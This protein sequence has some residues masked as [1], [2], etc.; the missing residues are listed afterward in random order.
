MKI[1]VNWLRNYVNIPE[2]T[3][4]Y[5]LA[6]LLTIRTTEVEEIYNLSATF[7]H[8]VIGKIEDIKSHP[9]ADKLQIT[10][11][12]IGDKTLQIIC[13]AKNISIGQKVAVALPGAMIRW[14]GEGNLV[15]LES[16]KIRNI[17]SF[18]MICAGEEIGIKDKTD[19]ILDLSHLKAMPGTPLANALQKDDWIIDID[20]KSLT[21]RPDC[22]G[23]YGIARE[24][25]AITDQK[26]QPLNVFNKYDSTKKIIIP[27]EVKN[28]KLCPRYLSITIN[29]IKV[30]PSP[31]WLQNALENT[32]NRT[33]NN[34]VDATNF[35]MLELGNP[36]HAFD[37]S[38]I[39]QKL[40]IRNANKGEKIITLDNEEKTLTD[41]M[42]VVAD[43]KRILAIAGVKGGINSGITNQTTSITLEAA[44]FDPI[45]IRQTSGKIG[46]RT[47]AVQRFEKNLDPILAET[48]LD[49]L[50]KII[51]DICPQAEIVSKKNDINNFKYKPHQIKLNLKKVASKI[52]INIPLNDIIE[53]L[54]KLEFKIISTYPKTGKIKTHITVE[55]PSFRATKDIICPE[56]LI[57]EITRLYGYEKLPSKIPNLSIRLPEVNKERKEEN[58]IRQIFSLE[59]GFQ[60]CIDYSF[61][62]EKTLQ[63]AGL[64]TKDHFKLKNYLSEEQTHLRI[65][66]LPNLLLRAQ[67]NLKNFDSFKLYEIGRTYKPI[68]HFFPLEEKY[69]CGC[70]LIPKTLKNPFYNIRS[71]IDDLLIRLQITSLQYQKSNIPAPYAHPNQS[72]SYLDPRTKR[73]IIR[74]FSI[75]PQ[76]MNYFELVPNQIAA[77]E[78]NYSELHQLPRTNIKFHSIS[79]F[80]SSSFDISALFDQ[81]L[82]VEKIKN[83]IHK[84]SPNLIIQVTLFDFYQGKN[85]PTNKKSLTY[86]VI[87]QSDQR[88]LTDQEVKEI[89]Q[90]V[91]T[92]I[93][94]MGGEVRGTS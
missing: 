93:K 56:D 68:G 76:T 6:E 78:I 31:K 34:I 16:T 63:N 72:A 43:Q 21:H 83:Q 84:T 38:K 2:N 94:N 19:G 81:N 66:L 74:I 1:S 85:I 89:Q 15:K 12:N 28:T 41:S 13:G 5:Q 64:Q 44:N 53:N 61:Y 24:I 77:F 4:F 42:L 55:I 52:G 71:A 17:E 40:I 20:N 9:N 29:N 39:N 88:T 7:N 65:S 91:F 49:R 73:E 14:H 8:I 75:H 48:A 82:E 58:Y 54:K 50:V 27:V 62:S 26:L 10:K 37:T 33:I 35:V 90:K 87:L 45:S 57:E 80:P 51:L 69:I 22:W 3:D 60:E 46:I 25:A 59:L 11:T 47:E 67:Q 36:L 18:G 30:E 23:H 92:T 32:G 79:K 86:Q 70:Y